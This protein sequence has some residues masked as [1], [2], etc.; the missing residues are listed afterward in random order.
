MTYYR[1]TID[2]PTALVVATLLV[3]AAGAWSLTRLRRGVASR[4]LPGASLAL[5]LSWVVVGVFV[6]DASVRLA[7]A[8]LA[9]WAAGMAQ[10]RP[11]TV[12]VV[13]AGYLVVAHVWVLLALTGPATTGTL[14]IPG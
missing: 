8:A 4:L 6:Q 3:S 12:Q 10:L 13:V 1:N 9:L 7:Y 11:R 14:W 5:L 2:A